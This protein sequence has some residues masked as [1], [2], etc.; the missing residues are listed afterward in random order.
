[1]E[2]EERPCDLCPWSGQPI[3][4]TI[5]RDEQKFNVCI[6]CYMKTIEEVFKNLVE[7]E[8]ERGKLIIREL[9]RTKKLNKRLEW[10]IDRPPL[11]DNRPPSE[12]E[13]FL[14]NYQGLMEL[15]N[16]P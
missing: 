7:D 13:Y 14:E 3:Y 4:K 10:D 16:R 8:H 2:T 15:K 5:Y 1:M 12:G 6:D 9:R 11:I